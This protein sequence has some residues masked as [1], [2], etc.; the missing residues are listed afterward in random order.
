[1]QDCKCLK[2]EPDSTRLQCLA[3]DLWRSFLE[4]MP[5]ATRWLSVH[6]AQ[7]AEE[8]ECRE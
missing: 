3:R 6:Q 7:Q 1:M 4:E 8:K 5:V 2:A